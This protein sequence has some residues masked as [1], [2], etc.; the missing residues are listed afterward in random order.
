M[1]SHPSGS[2]TIEPTL[3]TMDAPIA[4]VHAIR[5]RRSWAVRASVSMA[6]WLHPWA[7]G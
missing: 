1:L 5:A 4:I 6:G 2:A 7:A 3:V